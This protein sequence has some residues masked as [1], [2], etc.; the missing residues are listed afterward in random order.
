M[1]K[2]KNA[3]F[4]ISLSGRLIVFFD[5]FAFGTFRCVCVIALFSFFFRKLFF[6]RRGYDASNKVHNLR[7]VRVNRL[8]DGERRFDQLS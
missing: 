1:I 4:L 5:P 8:A 7:V 3:F 6:D 2:K